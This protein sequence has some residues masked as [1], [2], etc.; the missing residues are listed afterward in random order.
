MS[1]TLRFLLILLLALV[2]GAVPALAASEIAVQD[3]YD[4]G[5]LK[6]IDSQLKVKTGQLAPDFILPSVS[7][8]KVSLS[9]YRGKKNVVLS[10][11]PAAWTPICSNQWP[12]YNL[13]QSM[14]EKGDAVL[15]GISVDNIPT[16]YAWTRQMGHLWFE[17]LSDFWPHGAIARQYGL[18]RTDG[19]SER[20]LI[21]IDKQGIIRTTLVMDINKLPNPKTCALQL[22]ELNENR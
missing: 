14:F 11:V 4:L 2:T 21:F 3:L 12:G 19:L 22:K 9:Q 20:A 1:S 7:G 8:K 15:L 17:V 16:L 6:P 13:Q 5:K 18:L 10:F